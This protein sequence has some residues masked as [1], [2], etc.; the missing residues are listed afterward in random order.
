M[1]LFNQSDLFEQTEQPLVRKF[2]LPQADVT[3]YERFFTKKESDM[4]Y[5]YLIEN[6]NWQQDHMR[7]YGKKV[8]L[9]RLTAW[10]GDTKRPYSYSGIGMETQLWTEELL[11]IKSRVE[12][13]AATN[14]SGVLLN[15]YR[16]GQDSVSWHTDNEKMLGK[17]PIIGSVTFGATRLFQMRHRT[18]KEQKISIPLTH[19]ALLLMKGSTQLFWEHQVP[20]TNKTI[21]PRINLTFRVL[22]PIL[23]INSC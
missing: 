7:I 15:Y 9:P 5:N 13:V 2:D 12:T 6:I 23:L 22:D 8:E 1:D 10:Y 3:L 16:N 14:F 4:L 21:F 11:F 18:N 20:K 17:D 19:G